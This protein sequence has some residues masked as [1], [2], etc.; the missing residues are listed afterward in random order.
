MEP[1]KMAWSEQQAL[2]NNKERLFDRI[3]NKA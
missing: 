1:A 2:F 3:V